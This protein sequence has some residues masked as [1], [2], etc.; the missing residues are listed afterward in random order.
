MQYKRNCFPRN[1]IFRISS[2]VLLFSSQESMLSLE[3]L[4]GI[5]V[6]PDGLHVL[7]IEKSE[8][9]LHKLLFHITRYSGNR[10][11][12]MLTDLC[13]IELLLLGFL[14][15]P[16][17]FGL[18]HLQSKRNP[19]DQKGLPRNPITLKSSYFPYPA[20]QILIWIDPSA[21]EQESNCPERSFA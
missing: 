18:V 3:K 17:I 7:I 13:K 5:H 4:K 12:F 6:G 19:R 16:H 15:R 10:V 21:V 8:I 11:T 9:D 14:A 1:P 20:Q 2:Y